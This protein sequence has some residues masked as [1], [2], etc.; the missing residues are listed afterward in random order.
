MKETSIMRQ[1][2]NYM[3]EIRNENKTTFSIEKIKMEIGE[4][5]FV[6]ETKMPKPKSKKELLTV[7]QDNYDKLLSLVNAY[8]KEALKK[9]FPK[10]TLNRNIKDVLAHLHHWHIML[11]AWYKV[12]MKGEKPDMPA[13][14]YTWQT[15]PDLNKKI[16]QDYNDISLEEAKT[17]L[18]E[19]YSAVQKIIKRHSEE[20][21]FEKKRYK[22]TGS[23]SL[24]AYLILNT[25]SHYSW[26]VKLI[27]KSMK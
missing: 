21:L 10:G 18:G 14:G 1:G 2:K 23:T 26:A 9:E 11:L 6:K 4:N 25:V 20:E 15:L 12:G 7:S 16:K 3:E 8:S 27:K 19:S 24:G 17:L 5:S 13:K 22:W